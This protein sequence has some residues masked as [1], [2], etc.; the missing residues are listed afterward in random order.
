[1]IPDVISEPT[2]P[3]AFTQTHFDDVHRR[4]EFRRPKVVIGHPKLGLGGSESVVMWLIEALKRSFDVTIATTG[5]WD[6]STLNEFY[7]TQVKEGDV[8]VRIAPLPW[9]LQT[10]SVA[11]LRGAVY[12]R[13]AR[14]IAGEYDVRIS[15]YNLTDWGLPAIQ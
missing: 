1:M 6:R 13:F 11:A 10:R 9:P 12:Q 14:R 8:S 2:A 4:A 5:G 15:T 3:L 7:G